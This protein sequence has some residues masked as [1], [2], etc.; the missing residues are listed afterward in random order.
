MKKALLIATALIALVAVP[1]AQAKTTKQHKSRCH[2]GYVDKRIRG[3]HHQ[4][5][6]RCER[7]P[8]P[9][10]PIKTTAPTLTAAPTIRYSTRVDPTFTQSPSNP[11]AVTYSYSADAT[12][13]VDGVSTDLAQADD[14]PI[15]IL[16]LYGQT[17]DTEPGQVL[18]CSIEV[19]GAV[20]GGTCGPIDYQD[21]GT[22]QLTTDYVVSATNSTTSTETVTISP[23]TTTTTEQ[24][25]TPT[26]SEPSSGW[27]TTLTPTVTD[28]NGTQLNTPTQLS[29]W[30]ARNGAEWTGN[31][32]GVATIYEQ[33]PYVNGSNTQGWL[34]AAWA[35]IPSEEEIGIEQGDTLYITESYAGGGGWLPSAS[36]TQ[37]VTVP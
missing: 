37:T 30:D 33:F 24:L 20:S 28:Q 10:T 2:A 8:K 25:G 6:W 27:L 17:S 15:G 21:L 13:T 36:T 26:Y 11:L 18:L 14:L 23:F 34:S 19:G 32:S 9:T 7:K 31:G 16:Q 12:E 4:L 22:F 5:V 35:G 1:A 3:K 29:I